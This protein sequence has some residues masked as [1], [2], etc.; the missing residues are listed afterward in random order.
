MIYVDMKE[1]WF[2]C[3]VFEIRG[4]LECLRSRDKVSVVM[5]GEVRRR[6]EVRLEGWWVGIDDGLYRLCFILKGRKVSVL[7]LSEMGR[8]SRVL[9]IG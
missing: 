5:R 9:S 8:Y 1:G 2:R 4:G 3:K 6:L 7:I